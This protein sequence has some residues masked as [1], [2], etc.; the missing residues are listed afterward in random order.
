[1]AKDT[2]TKIPP[3]SKAQPDGVPMQKNN[4]MGKKFDPFD[5]PS[6]KTGF[7][8]GGKVSKSKC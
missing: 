8:K 2:G 5:K 3:S 4:A 7:S 6:G 1:M